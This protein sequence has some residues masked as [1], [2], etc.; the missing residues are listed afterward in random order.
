MS[1]RTPYG[2]F[3]LLAVVVL[4]IAAAIMANTTGSWEKEALEKQPD[5]QDQPTIPDKTK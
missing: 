5:F 4:G 1:R 3:T 2:T